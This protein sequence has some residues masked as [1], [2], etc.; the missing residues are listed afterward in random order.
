M[1]DRVRHALTTQHPPVLLLLLRCFGS[2]GATDDGNL[3]WLPLQHHVMHNAAHA[4]ERTR[5]S[6]TPVRMKGHMPCATVLLAW[7]GMG[8]FQ[9]LGMAACCLHV[10]VH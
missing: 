5:V 1:S 9:M 3:D 6:E 4:G 10:H 2:D 7:V 8:L